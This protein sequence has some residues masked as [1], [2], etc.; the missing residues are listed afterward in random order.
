[1]I[2][3]DLNRLPY[4]AEDQGGKQKGLKLTFY[5]IYYNE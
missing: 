4:Y 3:T 5:D 2:T 1:M